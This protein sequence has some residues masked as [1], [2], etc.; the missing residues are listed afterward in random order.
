MSGKE[1]ND[2]KKGEKK[3][4][5]KRILLRTFGCQMND[6]DS[7]LVMGLLIQD[8]YESVERPEDAD[9]VLFVTCSVRQ[10]AEDKVWSE[11][12]RVVKSHENSAGSGR[13]PIIGLLGCMAEEWKKEA[14]RKSS[15]IDLVVGPNDIHQIPRLLKK[16]EAGDERTMAVGSSRRQSAVYNTEYIAG[17]SHCNVIITEG[18]DNFCTYCIV[19]YVRGRER[20]RK[21][22]DILAEIRELVDKGVSEITLLG[23]NV[24]S[25]R[26][27]SNGFISLLKKVNDVKGVEKF[28]F[29]TSHPKDA[30][31]ELFKAMSALDKCRKFLHL[32]VQSGSNRILKRMNRGYVREHYLELAEAARRNI[33][34]LRMTTDV[35][36]GFPGETDRDFEDTLN[37]MRTVR[38]QGAYIFKYS[39]R[40]GTQAAQ[41]EDDVPMAVKRQRNQVLLEL[42][43]S[44]HAQQKEQ[45][46]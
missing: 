33:P 41:M 34:D 4:R 24:N 6:R 36:V 12:G 26:C 39:P 22:Q 32:P 27:G 31:E 17:K 1:K 11:I 14:F 43:K 18:C 46:D 5:G 16:L 29:V 40:P 19:P 13:K 30:S 3:H 44:L 37:L 7:E 45:R 8:G 28:D 2:A 10:K 42:Q 35:M 15:L 23:Q 20:S 38:F 9:I 25:Y 21:E